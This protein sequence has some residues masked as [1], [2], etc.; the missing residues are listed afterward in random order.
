MK[1]KIISFAFFLIII[2]L[3]IYSVFNGQDINEI[4]KD[5]KGT[6]PVYI[7]LSV[8]SVIIFHP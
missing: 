5:I 7:A 8:L 3:T 2:S 4:I 6:N 1:K